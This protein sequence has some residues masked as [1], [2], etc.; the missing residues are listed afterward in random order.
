MRYKMWGFIIVI[1]FSLLARP[2]FAQSPQIFMPEIHNQVTVSVA[3]ATGEEDVQP[4]RIVGG[5]LGEIWCQIMYIML[6]Q[7]TEGST[8]PPPTPTPTPTPTPPENVYYKSS[9]GVETVKLNAPCK[10]PTLWR[11]CHIQV[12]FDITKAECPDIREVALKY[13]DDVYKNARVVV[14]KFFADDQGRLWLEFYRLAYDY[15][16]GFDAWRYTAT[17]TCAGEDPSTP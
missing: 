9:T 6:L 8:V 7:A 15:E 11:H 17:A 10:W 12:R 4:C 13:T 5:W 3:N 16:D 2:L 14:D 1:V